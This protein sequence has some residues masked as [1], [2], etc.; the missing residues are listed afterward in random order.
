MTAA[1]IQS[2]QNTMTATSP[3]F[4]KPPIEQFHCITDPAKEKAF[5]ELCAQQDPAASLM[6]RRRIR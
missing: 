4:I 2:A 3:C 1:M 6:L 5:E